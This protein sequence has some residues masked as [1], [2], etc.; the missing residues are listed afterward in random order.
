MGL[1][2][3][4]KR[5]LVTAHARFRHSICLNAPAKMG[6]S[7]LSPGNNQVDFLRL[8]N[9]TNSNIVVSN[10]QNAVETGTEEIFTEKFSIF[11]PFA[12]LKNDSGE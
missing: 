11:V 2:P 1:S 4:G 10:I 6:A 5:R 12:K 8:L 9:P 3:T 7:C